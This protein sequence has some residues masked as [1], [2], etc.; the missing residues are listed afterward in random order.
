V[1]PDAVSKRYAKL[2]KRL[3]IDTPLKNLRHYNA[4]ELADVNAPPPVP[5]DRR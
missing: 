2:A 4:T 3:G 5:P 1:H